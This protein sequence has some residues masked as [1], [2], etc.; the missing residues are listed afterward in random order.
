MLGVSPELVVSPDKRDGIRQARAEQMAAQQRAMAL[1][2]AADTANKLAAARTDGP[3][4]LTD[5]TA[6]FSGYTQ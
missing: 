4:A 6:L 1:N 5:A 3:N 2:Q